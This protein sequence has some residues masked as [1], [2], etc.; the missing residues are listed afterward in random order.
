MIQALGLYQTHGLVLWK[1]SYAS[2]SLYQSHVIDLLS[3]IGS[4]WPGGIG[5]VI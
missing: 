4:R 2:P 3:V 1:L 5:F